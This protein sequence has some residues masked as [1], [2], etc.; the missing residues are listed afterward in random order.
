MTPRFSVT[1]Q[2]GVGPNAVFANRD[3]AQTWANLRYGAGN[4]RVEEVYTRTL[5]AARAASPPG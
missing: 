2:Q 1:A 4:F 5:P 3:D